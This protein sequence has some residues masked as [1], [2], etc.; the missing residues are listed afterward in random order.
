MQ[1]SGNSASRFIVDTRSSRYRKSGNVRQDNFCTGYSIA[2][3]AG[4]KMHGGGYCICCS[5]AGATGAG[6]YGG[7]TCCNCWFCKYVTC[8]PCKKV[9]WLRR[10]QRS[11]IRQW[12]TIRILLRRVLRRVLRRAWLSKWRLMGTI[13]RILL[14]W[15]HLGT[16]ARES[17]LVLLLHLTS[18]I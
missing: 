1:E 9:C 13:L 17:L 2:G 4:V 14:L 18:I 11:R 10:R 16:R 3:G 6:V 15:W 12:T 7:R 8:W 5:I